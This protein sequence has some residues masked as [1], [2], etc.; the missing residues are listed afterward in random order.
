MRRALLIAVIVMTGCGSSSTAAH[1][2]PSVASTA[3]ASATAGASTSPSSGTSPTPTASATSTPASSGSLVHCTAAVPPGDNMIIATVTGSSAI[4]V[5]DIQDIAHPRTLCTFDAGAQNPKF[6]S[7]S[8][9]AYETAAGQIVKADLAGGGTAV[10]ATGA[11]GLL[12]G[13]Y[14]FSSDGSSVTYMSNTAW[15]LANAS[16]DHVLTTL[17]AIPGRGVSPDQDDVFLSFSPDGL[18]IALFQTFATGGSGAT[19]P[20]QVRRASDGS[21]VYSATGMT[22]AVWA[23]VPS[24]LFFRDAGG[25]MQRWDPASGLSAMLSLNWIGPHSSPDGRWIAYTFR[26]GTSAIGGVGFYSVQANSVS[27][28]SPPGRAGVHFLNNILVWYI[29]IRACDTCFGGEPAPTGTTYIYDIG[30]AS[31]ATSRITAMYDAWPHTTA[32]TL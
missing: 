9:V 29:G 13:Q 26:T 21:L 12:S 27:N 7:G 14:S 16:G 8:Q 5:R 24:R 22:M 10:V 3:S 17:P 6:V 20:D 32:P 15:H 23:S 11:T 31:E 18:Y 4:V 28:T 30:G 25:S 19:A 2:T 1:V